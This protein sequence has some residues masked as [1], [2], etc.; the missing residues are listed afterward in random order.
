MLCHL[1]S[2][3]DVNSL[4]KSV[5]KARAALAAEPP[6]LRAAHHSS[7]N[8]LLRLRSDKSGSLR[9]ID[10]AV[11]HGRKA[12]AQTPQGDIIVRAVFRT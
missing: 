11:D 7:L 10:E 9:D 4:S 1:G 3:D 5:A 6:E 8:I 2:I 12:A